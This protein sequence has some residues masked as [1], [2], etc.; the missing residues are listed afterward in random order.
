[1]LGRGPGRW[2]GGDALR[3]RLLL[4]AAFAALFASLIAIGSRWAG[5]ET[6]ASVRL[7]AGAL[8]L[9]QIYWARVA[10]GIA[11]LEPS[12]RALFDPRLAASFRAVAYSS[13]AAQAVAISGLA[14][15]L[16]PWLFL[17]GL[18]ACLG[19]AAFGF[20]RLLFVRPDSEPPA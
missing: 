2:S 16:A 6:G 18:L 7:G 19:Y 5:A 20:V 17:Y 12:E 1:M 15:V 9:G 14:A 4:A 8:L 13:W 3:I 10:T 11:R